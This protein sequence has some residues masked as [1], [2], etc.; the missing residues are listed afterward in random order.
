MMLKLVFN[1]SQEITAGAAAVVSQAEGQS[2]C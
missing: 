1:I 2:I